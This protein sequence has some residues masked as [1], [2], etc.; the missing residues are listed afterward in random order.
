MT[1]AEHQALTSSKLS[2]PA[3][4]LYLL[5][6]RHQARADLTQP[7]DYP[8]LGR[9]LA[10]QGEGEYRYRVTPA[11]LT[12][13][14][15]ELQR[16]GLLTLMERPH[17]QHYHGARFRL[18]LKNLQGLTPLPARQFAMYP[19]WRPDE[20]LD[21][22]A[23]LCGLLDSRFDETE[24]GEFIAYWLGRP[25]VFENQHQWMLRFVRQL[26]NRRALRRAP[27]LES[28][29]GYQQQA[30]PATTET[31]PSQRAREMMEEARRL[32]DE[33]QESHDEKDT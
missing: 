30:A 18:T 23:R 32:S 13:L 10:V 12:A 17:P 9:A 14:L 21:G 19:E 2:H 26:K 29:T 8:E 33:H 7:L 6:L 11:A 1:P 4:S 15:E 20:Q 28:H 5:Y 31:G 27:D 22:L 16:A 24:L 3:R 25:E